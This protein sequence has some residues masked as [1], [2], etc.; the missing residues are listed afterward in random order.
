MYNVNNDEKWNKHNNIFTFYNLDAG[1]GHI[2][3]FWFAESY[4]H[5]EMLMR[6]WFFTPNRHQTNWGPII[7]YFISFTIYVLWFGKNAEYCLLVNILF[8]VD[9]FLNILIECWNLILSS[10]RKQKVHDSLI[11]MYVVKKL[12]KYVFISYL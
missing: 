10:Y 5:A 9:F 12:D 7:Y 4:S 3:Y 11:L 1:V 2:H 6:R 8:E